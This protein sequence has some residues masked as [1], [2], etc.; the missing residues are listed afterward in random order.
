M[1]TYRIEILGSGIVNYYISEALFTN[2]FVASRVV[3]IDTFDAKRVGSFSILPPWFRGHKGEPK[4]VCLR[5]RALEF[6]GRPISGSA[7]HQ[8]VENIDWKSLWTFNPDS[9]PKFIFVVMGLDCWSSRVSAMSDIR[10]AAGAVCADVLVIQAALEQRQAQVSVFGN[11]WEDHCVVC[12]LLAIPTTEPCRVLRTGGRLLRGDL[13]CEAAAAAAQVLTV[14]NDCLTMGN[15]ERWRNTKINLVAQP[16][17]GKY[18]ITIRKRT[19]VLQ[20][21]GPHTNDAPM[22]PEV[23]LS[24]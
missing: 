14:I 5:N 6:L 13:C 12:G 20:C 19:R 15:F 8:F 11:S 18:E 24:D 2:S 3:G 22:R 23:L 10:Q 4:A 1:N 9:E 17:T 21:W 16:M 7:Y